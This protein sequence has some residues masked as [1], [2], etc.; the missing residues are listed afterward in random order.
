[1][2]QSNMMNNP[3]NAGVNKKF[4]IVKEIAEIL[5]VS[6]RTAYN[7]CKGTKEFKVITIGRLVRI[8]KESF[9]NWLTGN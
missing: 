5:C 2:D 7:L 4:Y 3:Q 6:E 8:N 1:M 9:D